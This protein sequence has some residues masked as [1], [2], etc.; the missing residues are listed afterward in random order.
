VQIALK[1][2]QNGWSFWWNMA[3]KHGEVKQKYL[4]STLENSKLNCMVWAA[5]EWD[6]VTAAIGF[7]MPVFISASCTQ[8]WMCPSYNRSWDQSICTQHSISY[9]LV[10]HVQFHSI[11]NSNYS[12][13][14]RMRLGGNVSYKCHRNEWR[15]KWMQKSTLK[16]PYSFSNECVFLCPSV[17]FLTRDLV[18]QN[19][20]SLYVCY[21]NEGP[22]CCIF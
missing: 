1:H 18:L 3:S 10:T 20:I 12:S 16:C 7:H 15:L 14:L 17:N 5:A 2:L 11:M 19:S 21:A 22:Q 8:C 4:Q 9:V 6:T 13:L